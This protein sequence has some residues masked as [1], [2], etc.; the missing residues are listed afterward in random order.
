[1]TTTN[2]YSFKICHIPKM[3]I[4]NAFYHGWIYLWQ[5]HS[6]CVCSNC[7]YIDVLFVNI[8]HS[9]SSILNC[10]I[11]QIHPLDCL[12]IFYWLPIKWQILNTT[13]YCLASGQNIKGHHTEKKQKNI[14]ILFSAFPI[15]ISISSHPLL[16]LFPIYATTSYR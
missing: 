4:S 3:T 10:P 7:Y 12:I 2:H 1:M 6:F 13:V 11:C 9:H 8:Y 5:K 16:T 15:S 14:V